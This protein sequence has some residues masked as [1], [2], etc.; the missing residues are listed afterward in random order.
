MAYD[1]GGRIGPV[2]ALLHAQHKQSAF[3]RIFSISFD[4]IP[5]CCTDLAIAKHNWLSMRHLKYQCS[6]RKLH[7]PLSKQ[8]LL[9][10][11]VMCMVLKFKGAMSSHRQLLQQAF[12]ESNH[13]SN[14][15][16]S[17][18]E[19]IIQN[20]TLRSDEAKFTECHSRQKS[21]KFDIDHASHTR[22]EGIY[23][24]SS[25]LCEFGL[26]Y[27]TKNVFFCAW[28]DC[29]VLFSIFSFLFSNAPTVD[30]KVAFLRRRVFEAKRFD[31][32][33]IIMAILTIQTIKWFWNR[34]FFLHRRHIGSL[35]RLSTCLLQ[36]VADH[37]W[38]WH[39]FRNPLTSPKDLDF[40]TRVNES[41]SICSSL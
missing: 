14:V 7:I 27:S 8:N 4:A 31:S 41:F 21:S 18:K 26:L 6:W 13:N 22:N 11:Q 2:C 16:R 25:S 12:Q 29:W 1:C 39:Y 20:H 32:F 28:I 24:C 19:Q 37:S 35:K 3:Y 34:V 5:K 30:G 23:H 33:V 36:K 38:R 10:E 40:R 17:C 15:S 9:V